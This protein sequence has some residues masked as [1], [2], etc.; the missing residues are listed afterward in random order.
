MVYM[1]LQHLTELWKAAEYVG[2]Q[3]K[4]ST[5]TSLRHKLACQT[6]H[7]SMQSVWFVGFRV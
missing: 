5:Q 2:G 4:G 3:I 1:A 6:D 7:F